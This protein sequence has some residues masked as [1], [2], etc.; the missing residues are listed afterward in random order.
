MRVHRLLR[1]QNRY[2][3]FISMCYLP[4]GTWVV[5]SSTS[6]EVHNEKGYPLRGM[7]QSLTKLWKG[8]PKRKSSPTAIRKKH[9]GYESHDI[10]EALRGSDRS[11]VHVH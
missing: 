9:D 2:S 6:P 11:G 7:V 5:S 3:L 4:P 1:E 10:T 8:D